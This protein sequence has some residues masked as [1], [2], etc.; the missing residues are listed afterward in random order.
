MDACKSAK[1]RPYRLHDMR[2]TFNTNMRKAGVD[3]V[4]IM[5]LTD[6][7]TNEMFLRYSHI[8]QE[9]S[10]SAMDKLNG[11]LSGNNGDAKK[12]I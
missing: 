3:Q 12:E 1:V 4:V 9:Q 2:H 5:R 8:D 6:H 11:F 10:E 7:K